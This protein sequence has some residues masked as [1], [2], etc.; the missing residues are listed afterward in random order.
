VVDL[1]NK[2]TRYYSASGF[3]VKGDIVRIYP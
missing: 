3:K 1:N 2:V